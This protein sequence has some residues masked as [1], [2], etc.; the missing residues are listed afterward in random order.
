MSKASVEG[1]PPLAIRA[2]LRYDVVRRVFERIA[3]RTVL[4]V[5]CGQ[6][7]IGARLAQHSEYLAV[8][9]DDSSFAVADSRI[10]PVGGTVLHGVH[11]DVPADATFDVVCAFEV[12]EHL[13]DDNQALKDWVASIRPG[14][15]LVMSVPAFQSRFGPMDTNAGHFRRYEPQQLR[16]QLE[17][18]GLVDVRTTVYGWP[19]GYALEAVRNRIDARK[20]ERR[21]A[22]MEDLTYASGRTFQPPNRIV[23]LV[24]AVLVRPFI[25]L[26]RLRPDRGIGMVASARKPA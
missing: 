21:D 10:R 13:E 19:L 9:P 7:A 14:G 8:E 24:V 2:W 18:A 25:L 20:L 16:A 5:G 17:A 15:H 11:A 6:G 3:P 1:L 4:E 12:L 23:G 26:Q 22:S